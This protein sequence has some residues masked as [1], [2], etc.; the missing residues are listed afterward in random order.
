M[1][2]RVRFEQLF[3]ELAAHPEIAVKRARIGDPNPDET[4]RWRAVAGAFW[5]AGMT[6]LYQA[7]SSVELD[8]DVRGAESTGGSISIPTPALWDHAALENELWFDF[9]DEGS[10]LHAIRPIE[11]FVPEAYA[12]L[13]LDPARPDAEAEVAYH[14]CGEEL[15]PTGLTYRE[16]LE[17]LFRARGT[18]Y[19]LGLT[20][21]PS[22]DTTWVGKAIERVATMFPDFDP[23]S[24]RAARPRP[25]IDL[26]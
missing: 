4:A 22:P 7:L 19:W 21:H 2:Y 25:S 14:Y 12:V 16:W 11:R 13:Y 8:W 15:V 9:T 18:T 5:P 26:D 6:E 17:L 3:A 20:L 23:A 1:C 10:A 24:M